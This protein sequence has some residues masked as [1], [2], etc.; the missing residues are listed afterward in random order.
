MVVRSM[1]ASSCCTARSLVNSLPGGTFFCRAGQQALDVGACDM[2]PEGAYQPR[3]GPG[4]P[5][6][7]SERWGHTNLEWL[8][9][10]CVHR[11]WVQQDGGDLLLPSGQL[12]AEALGE[13]V[14]AGLAGA[15]GVPAAQLVVADGSHPR[16]QVG[17]HSRPLTAVQAGGHELCHQAG[18]NCST[19]GSMMQGGEEEWVLG[20]RVVSC[21]HLMQFDPSLLT[22]WHHGPGQR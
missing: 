6:K 22:L 18:V 19:V 20:H 5:G 4:K 1:M 9:Q 13:G 8:A 2:P 17:N 3:H 14:E 15:V 11:A 12:Y 16:R 7:H 21:M 10:V